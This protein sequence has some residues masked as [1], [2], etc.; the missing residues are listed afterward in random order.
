M[1]LFFSGVVKAKEFVHASFRQLPLF[2][3]ATL[4]ILG[5]METNV[6]YLFF[7]IGIVTL[8]GLNW[9]FQALL[10]LIMP[11][12]AA[13]TKW[14]WPLSWFT[15]S[16]GNLQ[17]CSILGLPGRAAA[18]E[19]G[20]TIV[21][22]SYFVSFIYFF[23]SYIALNAVDLYNRM[24]SD[25]SKSAKEKIDNR[26]YQAGMIIFICIVLSLFFFITRLINFH[27][28][29]T[30]FGGLLGMGLGVGFGVGWHNLLNYC[31]AS[32]ISDL[33][34][35]IGRLVPANAKDANP[36]ACIKRA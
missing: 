21:A 24:P 30:I 33:F 2:L 6:A 19:G 31:G 1:T 16:N 25:P 5:L 3:T 14:E 8:T 27:Q 28:C 29:E 4:F 15:S 10:N 9:A 20:R 18:I 34:G 13:A 35:I 23:F 32:E 36:V 22:P 11:K 17:G 7:V 12:L 26:K